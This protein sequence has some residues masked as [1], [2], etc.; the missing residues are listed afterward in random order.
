MPPESLNCRPTSVQELQVSWQPPPEEGRNGEIQGF[1]VLFQ[2][3]EEWYGK[4]CQHPP[5]GGNIFLWPVFELTMS[6]FES[7]HHTPTYTPSLHLPAPL[8]DKDSPEVKV[9]SS[10][11]TTLLGL[12]SFTN[13]SIVVLAFTG[14]GDGVRTSPIFCRTDE[15]GEGNG[16]V[17]S[18]FCASRGRICHAAVPSLQCRPPRPTSRR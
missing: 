14:S 4:Y 8:A 15:D 13:Y 18:L 17:L 3:T 11:S 5:R 6:D 1:K 10:T 12:L 9:T 2:P 7:Y 16:T